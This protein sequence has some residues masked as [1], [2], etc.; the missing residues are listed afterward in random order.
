MR[1][2]RGKLSDEKGWYEGAWNGPLPLSVGFAN[3]GI[4]QPHL[5]T[6]IT[7]LYLVA[8]HGGDPRGHRDDPSRRG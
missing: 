8:Q 6:R 1:L 7:E 4:D 3:A 5:H 2:H